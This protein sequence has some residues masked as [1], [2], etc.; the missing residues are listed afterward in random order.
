[1]TVKYIE[2]LRG[3]RDQASREISGMSTAERVEYFRQGA[4]DYEALAEK[5][6]RE[7]EARRKTDRGTVAD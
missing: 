7:R 3:I 1:M 4:R 2:M 6:A 5:A